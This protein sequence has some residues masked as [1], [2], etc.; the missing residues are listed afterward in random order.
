MVMVV[1]MARAR[2]SCQTS[3]EAWKEAAQEADP[4]LLTRD[5]FGSRSSRKRSRTES[6]SIGPLT[7]HNPPPQRKGNGE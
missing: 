3:A 4:S 7:P 2:A 6:A 5:S 1:V